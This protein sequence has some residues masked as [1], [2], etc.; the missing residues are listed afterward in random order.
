MA[1]DAGDATAKAKALDLISQLNSGAD[2]ATL[3]KAN[4]EDGSAS[5]GGAF[6]GYIT[7][8]NTTYVAEFVQGA[9]ALTSTGDY[10]K[11]PVKTQYGYRIIKA[12]S[13]LASYN[14]LKD[15]IKST[16]DNVN[17]KQAYDIYINSLREKAQIE[18]K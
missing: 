3:A 7:G 9:M 13:L 16:I 6:S 4:S 12:D 14:E 2:F 10:T 8:Y 1:T 11:E 18:K 15:D 17:K 5:S